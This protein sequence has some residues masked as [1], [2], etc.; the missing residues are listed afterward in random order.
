M[1]G[2]GGRYSLE[3]RRRST[4]LTEL[5]NEIRGPNPFRLEAALRL[6]AVWLGQWICK[7]GLVML[8]EVA[9]GKKGARLATS[10][11]A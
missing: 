3:V 9:A 2:T 11:T 4:R 6:L 1:H 10:W 7:C 8:A 5:T